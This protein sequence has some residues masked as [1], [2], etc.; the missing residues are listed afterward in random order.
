MASISLMDH[1]SLHIGKANWYKNHVDI[2]GLNKTTYFPDGY[3]MERWCKPA[4][5]A[6]YD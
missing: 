6:N 5:F 1:M 4:W 3:E 2:T